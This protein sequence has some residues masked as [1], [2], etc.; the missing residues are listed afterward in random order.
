MNYEV[1]CLNCGKECTVVQNYGQRYICAGAKCQ[2]EL[3]YNGYKISLR[4]T[5]CGRNIKADYVINERD[6]QSGR[7]KPKINLDDLRLFSEGHYRKC[8]A[9][10]AGEKGQI[11]CLFDEEG[12]N[13]MY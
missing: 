9:T 10:F 3:T 11:I 12:N 7:K 2:K 8:Y 1:G 13:E 6:P 4:V 5:G